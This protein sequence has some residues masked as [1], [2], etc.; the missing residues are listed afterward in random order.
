MKKYLFIVLSVSTIFLAIGASGE[1]KPLEKKNFWVPLGANGDTANL[2][3]ELDSIKRY[4][5]K[6]KNYASVWFMAGHIPMIEPK[7]E[8]SP[9]SLKQHFLIDCNNYRVRTLYS[10][11]YAENM[12]EGNVIYSDSYDDEWVIASKGTVLNLIF[13]VVCQEILEVK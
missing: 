1:F 11:Y 2:Y 9:S 3:I 12:G 8:Y 7:K 13:E 10:I 5:G 4:G 6:S